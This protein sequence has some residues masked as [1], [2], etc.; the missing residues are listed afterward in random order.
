MGWLPDASSAVAPRWRPDAEILRFHEPDY[1]AALKRAEADQAV[2]DDDRA[3][4]RI[5]AEGNPVYR[6]IYRRP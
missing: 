3:R 2:S 6:E 5:G 4:F 1:L